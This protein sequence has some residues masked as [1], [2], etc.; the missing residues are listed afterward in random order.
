M[1]PMCGLCGSTENLMKTPCCDNWVC[2][3][4][5]QYVLFS[6][7]RNSCCRNHNR[8]T[9][10]AYH[11]NKDHPGKWQSCETCKNDMPIEHYVDYGTN[12]CN[13]EKLKNPPKI[14]ITCQNCGFRSGTIQDF[15]YQ[16]S[17]G[18]YCPKNKCQEAAIKR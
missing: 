17:D 15:A 11:Y 6:Y 7:A 14:S 13:F 9:L 3:D 4:E 8:Y 12:D 10:C 2:D 1:K 18:W 5:D 16:T